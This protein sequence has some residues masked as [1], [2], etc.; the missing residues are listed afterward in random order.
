LSGE[1][2]R[3]DLTLRDVVDADLPIFFEQ[4]REP[5]GVAM[6]AFTAK[7]PADRSAFE[8]HWAKNRADRSIVM[9]TIVVDGRIAGHVAA[10]GPPSEREV[11][12]WLGREFWG[13][14]LASRALAAF[15]LLVTERPLH[16]RAAKDNLASLRVLQK[17]GF[18]V[19]GHD[20]GYANARAATIEEVLLT[21]P[22]R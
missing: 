20:T 3:H 10:F 16:A 17:C 15:L 21:L 22:R 8:A 9:K 18:E 19:T 12:Y 4:Q 14:G 13:R 7:D 11:T 5:E 1:A 6:A 2:R